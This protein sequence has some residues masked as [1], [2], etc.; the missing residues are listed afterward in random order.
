MSVESI[1]STV[2]DTIFNSSNSSKAEKEFETA[3]KNNIKITFYYNSDCP[4]PLKDST[5]KS[6]V[7]YVKA[8]F[9]KN[10]LPPISISRIKQ[11]KQLLSDAKKE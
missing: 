1:C 8:T 10:I 3:I 7:L 2:A 6:L 5:D 11:N 4:K 9:L